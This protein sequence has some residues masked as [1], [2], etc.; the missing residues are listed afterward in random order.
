M[1][2][3]G[4]TKDL[5]AIDKA[6]I[7]G[8]LVFNVS[9]GLPEGDVLYNSKKH[10][11]ILTH[12]A[13]ECEKRGLSFGVHNC[14]GWTS[15]GG[16]WVKPEHSMKIVV[17]SQTITQGGENLEL[18]LPQPPTRYDYY[19][20][21]AVVAYPSLATELLDQK[22]KPIITSSY[23]G[24][25]K[26]L[27]VDK[28]IDTYADLKAKEW[29]QYDFGAPYTIQS[30][31]LFINKRKGSF[32]LL[33]SDDGKNFTLV[34][35]PK[36]E[37]I[38]KDECYF[39]EHFKAVTA[40]YFRIV[41][42][43][44]CGIY[45]MDLSAN[46]VLGNALE[47]TSYRRQRRPIGTP[48]ASDII[49]KDQIVV[50]TDKMDASGILTTS[51]P[52]GNWTIMR[53]GY[54]TSGAVNEPASEEGTGLEVDKLSRE[55]LKIHYDAFVGKLV[56]QAKI[57]APNALQ[58]VEIDSY[59][60]GPQNWT[61]GLES[62]FKNKFGYDFVPFLPMFA[63]KYIEN[64]ETIEDVFWDMKNLVSDLMVANYFD[65]FTEL[66][67]KD[68]LI[69][70]IEPYGF[71]GPFNSLDAGRSADIPM[72]EFWL[73][74]PNRHKRAPV[75]SGHIYGKNV[76]SAEAFT[77]TKLNWS[78]H[79]ALAKQKGDYEWTNG[80]NEYMFHRFAH[81][82][83]IHVKPGM[84]MHFVGSH[85]DRTQ[86]WWES[87]GPAWFQYLSR[88]SYMLRQGNPVLDLLVFVG[89]R[90]P[91][92]VVHPSQIKPQIPSAYKYD[93]VNSDVI[94]NR[95]SVEKGQLVLPN[96]IIYKALILPRIQVIS[97]E[98]LRGIH[99]LSQQGAVIIGKKPLKYGGY[100][101][102]EA[103]NQEFDQ[104]VAAIWSNPKTY[105]SDEW[106]TIFEANN[107]HKDLIVKGQPD[108]NYYHRRTEDEDIYFIYNHSLSETQ[109][110]DCSFLVDG[111]VP[112]LWRPMNGKVTV[113][114][115]YS[116]NNGRTN[117]PI[118]LQPQ[119]SV[120]VVFSKKSDNLP[121]VI[122]TPSEQVPAPLFFTNE[123][124]NEV[125]M[126][127]E[128][129]GTYSCK[130]NDKQWVSTVTDLPSPI[131]VNGKWKVDFREEDHYK[132]SLETN[133]LF[134]WS[135]HEL[136]TIKHY[137]GTAIYTTSFEVEKGTLQ[138]NREFKLDLGK[139]NVIASVQL[140]GVDVGVSWVAPY[141]LDVTSGLKEGRNELI[142]K[143]TNQWT[144]RLIGD[145][146][147]PN[148][149]NYEIRN[150]EAG[151]REMMPKWFRKNKPLPKGPRTTFSA[152]SFQKATDKLLPSGLIGPVQILP[153]K[154]IT[155]KAI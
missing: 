89:D 81:Q 60:V 129:N 66:C 148:Q 91:N 13:K 115:E 35:K 149:I 145:E 22:A 20:D 123:K 88:G 49:K 96:G 136:D 52:K 15:S 86:T 102:T 27:A 90:A 124:S 61:D 114:A 58:Y 97:L 80:I 54:T 18:A 87:A 5:E 104:L 64:T 106:E 11:D 9:M 119:E 69:S 116:H 37:R 144:N 108:F 77:S 103:M 92:H 21:I 130:V 6:G 17:N 82:S 126:L 132:G 139:V 111:K 19:K 75:S 72:G 43:S 51:L 57:D 24:F 128:G 110:L 105:S 118:Q 1:S 74:K 3:E 42:A 46:Y 113:L 70:Y 62:I 73:G 36:V 83:N 34:R 85:I 140:N 117:V 25:D 28:K 45:E 41:A 78:F 10:R 2:K 38:G 65:Y 122:Y 30:I 107:I 79:P 8:I 59:E 95:I 147:L 26:N 142:I 47:F 67:H 112:E 7:G 141:R 151:E 154:K 4:F 100:L 56:K 55:A 99:Q 153:L 134:D 109:V 138:S 131:Q 127:V 44:D 146:K 33:K 23:S 71:V 137:S 94:I 133:Y 48:K 125:T 143:V 101:K 50:L 29:V 98:T 93:C 76:I 39:L 12:G 121:K 68:G 152:F 84:S 14:D 150:K 135:E 120:F 16:P 53:F 155:K 32:E 63:G 40:R 31:S